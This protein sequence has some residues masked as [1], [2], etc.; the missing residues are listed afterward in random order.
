ML[1]RAARNSLTMLF[2]VKNIV[3]GITYQKFLKPSSTN[4]RKWSNTLE[5]F[6]AD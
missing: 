4:R 1:L 2:A 5:Q 3:L 6:V